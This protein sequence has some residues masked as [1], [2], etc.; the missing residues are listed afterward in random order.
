VFGSGPPVSAVAELPC[1]IPKF[2]QVTIARGALEIA[3]LTQHIRFVGTAYQAPAKHEM[4]VFG[5]HRR[6]TSVPCVAEAW[7]V[8]APAIYRQWHF[9]T[10]M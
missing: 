1:P 4:L 7:H 6:R 8:Q 3:Q 2:G 5:L 10:F 9:V